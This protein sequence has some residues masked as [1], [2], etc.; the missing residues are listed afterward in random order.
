MILCTT[1][2]VFVTTYPTGSAVLGV[3][4]K[5]APRIQHCWLHPRVSNMVPLGSHLVTSPFSLSRQTVLL[6]SSDREEQR[7][8]VV[9][10][11]FEVVVESA[12]EEGGKV[13]GAGKRKLELLFRFFFYPP[14]PK[15]HHQNWLGKFS[16]FSICVHRSFEL[17][18]KLDETLKN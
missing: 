12:A 9:K 6:T 3:L 17:I 10:K 7:A 15:P 11:S 4:N 5:S 14:H 1:L 13:D 8:S 2:R 16:T 18:C